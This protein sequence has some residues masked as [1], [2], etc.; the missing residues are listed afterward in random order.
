MK[1]FVVGGACA[2]A[3]VLVAAPVSAATVVYMQPS[4]TSASNPD[5]SGMGH[6]NGDNNQVGIGNTPGT[7][8]ADKNNPNYYN[9]SINKASSFTIDGVFAV[10]NALTGSAVSTV[11]EGAKG[12]S[13]I[14]ASIWE[15]DPTTHDLEDH[16][17]TLKVE[18]S[19]SS[20]WVLDSPVAFSLE[21]G[22][23]ALVVRGDKTAGAVL[24]YQMAVT[25]VP[26]PGAAMMFGAGLLVIGGLAT[27]RKQPVAQAI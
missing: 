20:A 3:A 12:L 6:L 21:P 8:S 16:V 4:V 17:L 15:I 19:L 26:L 18:T 1:S 27:R 11:L 7:T 25:S 5:S 14:R 22:E 24:Q 10:D 9:T 13:N 2:L 23:Y